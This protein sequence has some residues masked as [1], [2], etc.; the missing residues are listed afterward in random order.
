MGRRVDLAQPVHRDQGVDL[1]GGDRRVAEQFLDHPDVGPA[2][3][4]VRGEGVP[5]RVR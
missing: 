2:V 3:E 1:G 4:H 5:Q